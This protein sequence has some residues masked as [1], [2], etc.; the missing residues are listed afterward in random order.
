MVDDESTTGSLG[1]TVSIP[2]I[3]DLGQDSHGPLVVCCAPAGFVDGYES[4]SAAQVAII[5]SGVH[6]ADGWLSL[7]R[8]SG[9]LVA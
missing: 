3:V 5:V 2:N 9:P 8:R 7:S 4:L 6:V 1:R